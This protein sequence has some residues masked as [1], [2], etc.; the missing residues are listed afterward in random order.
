MSPVR[1]HPEAEQ[2]RGRASSRASPPCKLRRPAVW[3]SGT[4]D[5]LAPWRVTARR[6]RHGRQARGAEPLVPLRPWAPV[7]RSGRSSLNARA[8]RP[9]PANPARPSA[10]CS[11]LGPAPSPCLPPGSSSASSPLPRQ[12]A[13]PTLPRAH[14]GR[15]A[16]ELVRT[17]LSRDQAREPVPAGH[18]CAKP[19]LAGPPLGLGLLILSPS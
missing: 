15:P 11:A 4:A 5:V 10:G 8:T 12:P 19:A 9:S 2:D 14:P 1:R 13:R 18:L 6:L 7:P 17:E 3:T 16:A